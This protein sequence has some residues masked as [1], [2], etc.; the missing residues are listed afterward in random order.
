MNMIYASHARVHVCV[1]LPVVCGGEVVYDCGADAGYAPLAVVPSSCDDRQ[2][3]STQSL[4]ISYVMGNQRENTQDQRGSENCT[5]HSLPWQPCGR[6]F[7][8]LNF[9]PEPY[10]RINPK[11]TLI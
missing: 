9:C 7:S 11:I 10:G 8:H 6:Y 2:L 5:E 1:C 3:R 4:L